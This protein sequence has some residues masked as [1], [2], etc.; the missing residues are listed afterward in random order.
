MKLS[1][2]I[3]FKYFIKFISWISV[4]ILFL[5]IFFIFKESSMF[6]KTVGIK[7]L[8]LND[9]WKPLSCNPSYGIANI[10]K[11]TIYTSILALL[12][13]L[14]LGVGTA[15]YISCFM[16]S[17]LKRKVKAIINI[18]AGIPSVIYGFLGLVV[19]IPIF[20]RLLHMSAGESVLAGGIIL[21]IM[22]VPYIINT[23]EESISK[24]RI[25]NIN[26]SIS[27]GVSEEYMILSLIIPSSL[28]SILVASILALG[29]AMGE[30]MAVMMVIG[31]A[32]IYPHILG[33]AQTIPSLIALEMGT[34]QI[35]SMHYYALFASGLIL[36]L[37]LFVINIIFYIL[38]NYVSKLY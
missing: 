38:K 29:R 18:L 34:A 10:L 33:K 20:E 37:L 16:K 14:P 15:L 23:C 7:P 27:L 8:L 11:A 35:D 6:F 13:A 12:L 30:T 31:N 1:K 5:V 19:L 32:P 3:L 9:S 17:A 4:S 2:D 25:N 22:I 26:T 36:M 24:I 28:K 21:A